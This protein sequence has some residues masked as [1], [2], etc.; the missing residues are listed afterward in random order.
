MNALVVGLG[1][2]G[3]RHA[4]NW[5]ELGLGEVW[6]CRRR[7]SA[8]QAAGVETRTFFDLEEALAAGPDLVIVANP[9]SLHVE[10]ARAAV[11]AGCH[12]LVEKP[13]DASTD[14][15]ADLLS[16]VRAAGV[17]LAV[18]YNFRFH[19]LV[20]RMSAVIQAGTIG[21][22]VS[23]R[24]SAGEYLPAWHPDE[25]YRQGYSARRELGGGPILTFSHDLDLL[26]GMLGRP[27]AVQCL[28]AHASTLEITTEDV[29][30]IG[31]RFASGAIG[32][33]HVDFV[34]RPPRRGLEIVGEEGTIV[35]EYEEDRLV[36]YPHGAA[37]GVET[38]ADGFSRNDMVLAEIRQM[39]AYV[40]HGDAGCL[41]SGPQGAAILHVAMAAHRAAAEQ[42]TVRLDEEERG[43]NAHT[44]LTSLEAPPASWLHS[45]SSS[46]STAGSL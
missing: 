37:A 31:L 35:W 36:V 3:K 30:E 23:G 2:A 20:R 4:R 6:A 44:W 21:R 39:V 46:G 9:T 22:P 29:A 38:S 28:A 12:V 19:P 18:G 43:S 15:V 41:A 8:G 42:V 10:T 27:V 13:L 16:E 25:D 5:A 24:A 17:R 40:Q 34:R 1:S 7:G 14:A 26:C 11:R 45:P 32:S 33:V